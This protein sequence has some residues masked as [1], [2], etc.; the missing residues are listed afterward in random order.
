MKTKKAEIYTISNAHLDTSWLWT[1][2]ETIERY[3]PDTIKCN[4]KL[5]EK[6][7]EYKFNFEGSLRYELIKEYYARA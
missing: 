4:F 2:E 7:P 1:L 6:Y 5:L 3:I